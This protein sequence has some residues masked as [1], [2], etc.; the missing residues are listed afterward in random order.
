MSHRHASTTMEFHI[1]QPTLVAIANTSV[2]ADS[3]VDILDITAAAGTALA[4][5]ATP[6]DKHLLEVVARIVVETSA[7]LVAELE[8]VLLGKLERYFGLVMVVD[9]FFRKMI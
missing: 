3:V 2:T 7:V 1:L 6:V 8:V 9:P 5:I 4:S